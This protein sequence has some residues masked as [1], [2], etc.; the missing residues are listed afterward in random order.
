MVCWWLFF[1]NLNKQNIDNT[2]LGWCFIIIENLFRSKVPAQ[3]GPWF[4]IKI[5]SYQYRK[6][7]CGD[8]TILRPSYLHNG[9]SYTGKM[10]SLYWIRPQISSVVDKDCIWKCILLSMCPLQ[11]DGY[12]CSRNMSVWYMPTVYSLHKQ[13]VLSLVLWYLN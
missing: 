5:V 6:S 10:I 1:V 9:I 8:K 13:M 11:I 4:N 7:H 3:P 12:Q 2:A